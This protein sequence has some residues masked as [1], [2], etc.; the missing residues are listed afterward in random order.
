MLPRKTP[1]I[2]KATQKDAAM[3]SKLSVAAFLPAHGQSASKEIIDAYIAANFSE[4]N[5]K[6][7]LSNTKFYTICYTTMT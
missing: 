5:F 1:T 3:L 7:E 6:A 4:E 2:T